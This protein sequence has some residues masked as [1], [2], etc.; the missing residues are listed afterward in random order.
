MPLYSCERCG[1]KTSIK[2]H[3]KNHLQRKTMCNSILSKKN[4]KYLLKQNFCNLVEEELSEIPEFLEESEKNCYYKCEYCKC[5]FKT[6]YSKWRH[7]K[8]RCN[9]LKNEENDSKKEILNKDELLKDKDEQLKG[10]DEIIKQLIEQMGKKPNII[11]NNNNTTNNT[12]INVQMNAF[13][14]EN[15]SY[16][17]KSFLN[18]LLKIPYASVPRLLEFIHFNKNAP[19]NQNVKVISRKEK[20]AQKHNGTEWEYIAKNT[21]IC[22]MISNGV[23]ILEIHFEENG[24]KEELNDI[25]REKWEKFTIEYHEEKPTIIKRLYDDT[26]CLLL[27]KSII[28]PNDYDPKEND[29]IDDE[30]IEE[31]ISIDDTKNQDTLNNVD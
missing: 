5:E 21:L 26:E 3:L 6:Y 1:W 15:L 29:Q 25:K 31:I 23:N 11:N 30:S 8:S 27:N 16:I 14:N 10:K 9:N 13:G 2:T 4:T 22:D 20:W 28:K 24:G 17:S 19:E 12:T 18:Q 7:L